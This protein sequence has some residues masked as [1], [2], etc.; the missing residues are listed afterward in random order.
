MFK[1]LRYLLFI[2]LIVLLLVPISSSATELV[3]TFINPAFGGNAFN[4]DWLLASAQVQNKLEQELSFL[5]G[6]PLKDFQDSLNRQ[7]LYRLSSKIIDVAFGESGLESG[8]YDLGTYTIDVTV[9]V[10]GI[11]IVLTDTI[12]GNQTTLVV[13]YY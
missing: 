3:F 9:T 12:T 1:S 13:P 7:I 11:K 10:D 5:D 8:H 4:A 6:D 2:T